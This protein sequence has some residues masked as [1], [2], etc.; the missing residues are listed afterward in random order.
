MRIVFVH[1]P[2]TTVP[3]GPRR[4]YWQNF[5]IR[6]HAVH[7]GLRPMK[8]VTWELPHW[9]HWLGG[10][11]QDR[12]YTDLHVAD[13]YT[14]TSIP[15]PDD[16]LDQHIT[17][18]ALKEQPADVYLFS[19]MTANL[20]HALKIAAHAKELYPAAVTIFGGVVATPLAKEV[21]LQP[22][23]DIVVAGQGERAL[24]DFLDSLRGAR[25]RESVGNLV[26]K[27]PRGEPLCWTPPAA[28]MTVSELPLPKIDLFPQ[29]TGDNLRYIR[30]VYALGCPYKCTFCTIQTIG[31]RPSYFSIERVL[32]EIRA[33]RN[34]YGAHHNIYFGD[35]TFT[36]HPE[37]TM[38]LLVALA[39]E[40]DILYDCQTRLN[41]LSDNRI[42]RAMRDSGCR[43]VEIGLETGI[44]DTLN[45]H[46]RG[47]K[48]TVAEETLARLRDFGLP[49]C[50]FI[51]NG[52][53]DQSLDDMRRT[54]EWV[55]DLIERGLLHASYFFGLVPYPGTPMFEQPERYGMMIEHR[56][57]GRYHQ[58]LPPVYHTADISSEQ[59]YDTFLAGLQD[60]ASAMRRRSYLGDEPAK[61]LDTYGEF[62]AGSYVG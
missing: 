8:Q 4:E 57:Y 42:L 25:S 5:D 56:D 18:S 3:L 60:I 11:L 22:A 52:F 35:E 16:E 59:I 1:T 39:R 27:S 24:P 62:W 50:S 41:C 33:Y 45:R 2:M 46:K 61:P 19:P 43:W 29:S 48:L 53:P 15:G 28:H 36:L 12:G 47:T 14:R 17:I 32:W 30:Q 37:K 40:G 6:Y 7:P 54:V 23:V 58:D 49:A 9:M 55:C 21:A 20:K 34:H 13:L 31:K 38:D 44:Q 10:V 26:Y 51:V